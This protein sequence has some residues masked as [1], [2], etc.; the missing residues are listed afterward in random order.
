MNHVVKDVQG[1]VDLADPKSE[2]DLRLD[3]EGIHVLS[4]GTVYALAVSTGYSTIHGAR[5]YFLM[6]Q[7]THR[8]GIDMRHLPALVPE[9]YRNDS[10]RAVEAEIT[11]RASKLKEKID[12]GAFEQDSSSDGTS[13]SLSA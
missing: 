11:S 2:D 6:T 13:S 3:F 7:T 10:A 8:H 4:T 5:V 1:K 9:T 12:A